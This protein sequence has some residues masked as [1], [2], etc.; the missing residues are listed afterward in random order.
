[1]KKLISCY[2]FML[3]ACFVS[4]QGVTTS[5]MQGQILDQS[6]E[7]LIGA[8]IT[9][10]HSPTGTLY[11]TITD[12][13]GYYRLDNLKVGGPYKITM[14]YVGQEDLVYDQ[15]YLRL[16]EPLRLNATLGESAVALNEIVVTAQQGSVG[17]NSGTSTQ[18]GAEAIENLPTLNRNLTDFTRLTPQA[19]GNSF[20]GVNNRYNA[21]YVDGAVNND[22]FGL[23]GSGTNGGQTG[24]SPFSIDIIDQIQV[25]LSPY[26]V[27]YGGF[28][29][30]GINAVTKSGTNNLEGTAYYFLQNQALVGKTNQTLID[31]LNVGVEDSLK[32]TRTNVDDFTKQTYG[33]S[34]GGPIIKNKVFFFANVELQKDET[35]SPFELATY[36]GDNEN[37]ASEADLNN[38]STVLRDQYGYDA[39][40]FGNTSDDLDG[41]KL[42]GKLDFNLNQDHKLTLR[43]QYTKAEQFNRNSGNSNTINFSNNGIYFPSI[44]NSSALELNSN[45]GNKMSNNLILGYTTV[46]DDRD[47]L[48]QPF[49]NVTIFEDDRG[50]IRFG[51]EAFSSANILD[52]KIFTLTDNFKIY[53]GKHTLTFGTHNE[54]YS[55]RNV[56]L[57]R[58]YGV[59]EF[60]SLDDFINGE[61]AV[62]YERTYSLFEG[63]V[64]GDETMAA[65]EFNAMQLGIYAQDEIEISNKFTLTAG[66]RIDMPIINDDPLE[67]ERF[68]DEV[69]PRLFESYSEF[70]GNVQA[71]VAPEGQLMFS[72]R[73]GFNYAV[74]KKNTLRG[75]VGIFTSRIPFV[76]PGAMFNTNGVTSTSVDE[77]DLDDIP[78]IA[79]VQNQYTNG[80]PTVPA[81]DL[82]L[83]TNDFKYPQVLKANLGYDTE[84]AGGW[85]TS[86]EAAFTKTLNNVRYTNINTSN[87]VDKTFTGSGDN[88]PIYERE[89]LDD[90]DFRAVYLASN[91]SM[92]YGYNLTASIQKDLIPNL[93]LLVA[94]NYGDSYALFEGTSSQNSS[95]WRG[96]VN[97]NGRNQASFGRSDFAQGSKLIAALNYDLDWANT[98]TTTFSLFYN[99][100]SGNA[101]SYVIGGDRDARNINNENGSTSRWRSL[102]YVPADES[103]INLVDILNDDGVVT[104]TAAQQWVHLNDF[105]ENDPHLSERRGDYAEKNGGRAP[106]VSFIDLA[107]RQDLGINLGEKTHKFQLS[108]DVFNVANLL[109]SNWG[110]RYNVPGSFNNYELLNFE[111]FDTD[112]TTPLYTYRAGSIEDAKDTYDINNFSSRWQARIGVRYIFN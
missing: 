47:P 64:A 30:A 25:V 16:G 57:P 77:R 95:Q 60:D 46:N 15:V 106:W 10:L 20:G 80:D 29:G 4:A 91:T 108:F 5:A 103:D 14:S 52:Q 53:K 19:S 99:G 102:I 39:G 73:V 87:V 96:S 2:I 82:N 18:I 34:L 84:F 88:R 63:D 71:G 58:N 17:K 97:V 69:L 66:L 78:F 67:A 104:T 41:V 36:N 101:I 23:A 8:T 100:A 79:D 32:T 89:E 27:T 9:A 98:M 28:A 74:S 72:P 3:I 12:E 24:I 44:T 42:F 93:N 43:H 107:I 90:D 109:N 37:R 33:A 48:G 50:A 112:G 22:V 40:T 45:F 110:V 70:E 83:F 92:G 31:R 111:E 13:N 59:Y 86:L 76:W 85:S 94:Y 65:A 56:F 68:N 35:P 21:I 11:G 54:F 81:G 75:G 1:M 55:I 49:P 38:L 6:E 61:S 7:T 105:I 51:G 26:D 62:G